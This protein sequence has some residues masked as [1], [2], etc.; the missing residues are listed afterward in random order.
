[1]RLQRNW[2][3]GYEAGYQFTYNYHGRS[4]VGMNEL[5]MQ[6]AIVELH[7]KVIVQA[8]DEKTLYVKVSDG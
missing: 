3:L 4:A 2:W 7:G 1:M 5:K 6:N 8:T